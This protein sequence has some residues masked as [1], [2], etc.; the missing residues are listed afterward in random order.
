MAATEDEQCLQQFVNQSPRDPVLVR[1]ALARRMGRELSP[2]AWVIDNAGFP[3]FGRAVGSRDTTR[4]RCGRSV[5]VTTP[6]APT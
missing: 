4:V 1:R 2:E 3:N 6:S 5:T